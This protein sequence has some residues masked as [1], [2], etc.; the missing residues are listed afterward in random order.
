MSDMEETIKTQ[1]LWVDDQPKEDFMNEAFDCGLDITSATCVSKGVSLL[2]DK[3]KAWDAI[4]LDANCKLTDDEQEQ[5]SLKALAEAIRELVHLRTNI[6]WF[7]YTG[8]DYEGVEFLKILIDERD[9]DDR[10]YYNKPKERYELFDNIKKAVENSDTFAIK[11]KYASVCGFYKNSDLVDLL[12][13]QEADNFDTDTSIPNRV[14]QIIEW[15]MRYF[16]GRGLLSVPFMGTNI[17]RCS[18]SLGE[19]PQLVPIHVAR[20]L[21]FCVE[22]CNNGSHGDEIIANIA[23]GE[24]PYLNKSIILNLLNILH[25]CPSLQKYEV[26]ELKKKVA[27]YQQETREKKEKRVRNLKNT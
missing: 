2:N 22:V 16:D 11:Q 21:H 7:V 6:P 14:R 17:A 23:G 5:P 25:W 9:Y 19:I 1:V 8:G 20:S 26:E 18:S 15:I 12:S 3:S 27:Q 4:I 13:R 24:A 10:L